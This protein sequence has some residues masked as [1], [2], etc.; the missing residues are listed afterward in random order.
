VL[1][2]EDVTAKWGQILVL[3]VLFAAYAARH[4]DG[5]VAH[6]EATYRAGIERSR[7]P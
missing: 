1:Y 5:T 2:G 4:V 6:L 7:M 3:D